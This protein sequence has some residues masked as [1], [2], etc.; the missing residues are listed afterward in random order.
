MKNIWSVS[1]IIFKSSCL[2]ALVSPALGFAVC[3]GT[4]VPLPDHPY[5]LYIDGKGGIRDCTGIV[6]DSRSILTSAHCFD[7]GVNVVQPERLRLKDKRGH[8][9]SV[10]GISVRRNYAVGFSERPN[11]LGSRN[12]LAIIKVRSNDLL[13]SLKIQSLPFTIGAPVDRD[14]EFRM[15][16]V[17]GFGPDNSKTNELTEGFAMLFARLEGRIETYMP[18]VTQSTCTGDS[19]GGLWIEDRISRSLVGINSIRI[20]DEKIPGSEVGAVLAN[21]AAF[22]DLA[23]HLCWIKARAP[24]A[25]VNLP[26]GYVC[27]ESEMR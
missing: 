16:M 17:R 5:N 22:T 12:D 13:G 20:Y 6:I 1:R 27:S 24:D 2:I 21:T 19:G 10:A 11:K 7:N 26:P 3:G 25:N 23:P 8:T 18:E 14:V 9:F 4:P 15:F